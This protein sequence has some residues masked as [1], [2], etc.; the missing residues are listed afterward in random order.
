MYGCSRETAILSTTANEFFEVNIADGEVLRTEPQMLDDA[1]AYAAICQS[2]VY[3]SEG[4]VYVKGRFNS[5]ANAIEDVKAPSLQTEGH[6]Y[7]MAGQ[8]VG[9]NYKGIVIKNGKK[10]LVK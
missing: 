9:K 3:R 1:D 6:S 8:R 10:Y 7:N 2:I 4:K 5:S